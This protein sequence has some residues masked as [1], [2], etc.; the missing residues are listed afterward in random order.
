MPLP[1]SHSPLPTKR[2]PESVANG[3]TTQYVI[4]I[5]GCV[6]KVDSCGD[7][8]AINPA[9]TPTETMVVCIDEEGT[10]QTL[11]SI[12]DTAALGTR[13][14]TTFTVPSHHNQPFEYIEQVQSRKNWK[15]RG[16]RFGLVKECGEDGKPLQIRWLN[17]LKIRSHVVQ[18]PTAKRAG[19]PALTDLVFSIDYKSVTTI[20]P[21]L[22]QLSQVE[23]ESDGK[24]IALLQC[25]QGGCGSSNCCTA[26]ATKSSHGLPDDPCNIFK[27]ILSAVTDD[28][29]DGYV[30]S[31]TMDGGASW[32]DE[33]IV[34]SYGQPIG[35]YCCKGRLYIVTHKGI[36]ACSS[37][38]HTMP[39][40]DRTDGTQY[41][42]ENVRGVSNGIVLHDTTAVSVYAPATFEWTAITPDITDGTIAQ[43]THIAT[44]GCGCY[45]KIITGGSATP[46]S[47]NGV[48]TQFSIDG[49][50]TFTAGNIQWVDEMLNPKGGAGDILHLLTVWNNVFV[51]IV[52]DGTGNTYVLTSSDGVVW[53]QS[54]K[55]DSAMGTSSTELV[56]VNDVAWLMLGR[57]LY[58][59]W[60]GMCE[61]DWHHHATLKDENGHIAACEGVPENVLFVH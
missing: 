7:F 19:Q 12:P 23:C 49:G 51:A 13:P 4:Q 33:D 6:Y 15:C 54:F 55:N 16:V 10:T 2:L 31:T 27:K 3:Q 59:N 20:N 53:S 21:C 5:D 50:Q 44:N 47:G 26:C 14:T 18:N 61:H 32:A 58:V 9:P 45:E 41:L 40:I 43:Q 38:S 22:A 30:I 52:D 25:G 56:I 36:I 34:T 57:D 17:D 37:D 39:F 35:A 46:Q 29:T 24:I 28:D 48:S 8:G 60:F 42:I 1:I 11:L